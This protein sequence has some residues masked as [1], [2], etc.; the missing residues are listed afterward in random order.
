MQ[1]GQQEVEEIWQ[2]SK[3]FP[4]YFGSNK[5]RVK[6]NKGHIMSP[7]T[8]KKG[9]KRLALTR[10]K[11]KFKIAVSRFISL[12]FTPNIDNLPEVDHRNKIRSDNNISNLKWS[13]RK[14]NC[15]NRN[16]PTFDPDYYKM[17]II[18]DEEWKLIPGDWVFPYKISNYGRIWV[19]KGKS[20]GSNEEYKRVTLTRPDKTTETRAI[21]ILVA[22]C[23]LI[24]PTSDEILIVDHKDENKHN[25]KASNLQ[26]ITQSKNTEKS[27]DAGTKKRK[28]VIQ[29]TLEGDFVAKF[30]SAKDAAKSLGIGREHISGT[31]AGNRKSSGGF[32]WVFE[33]DWDPNAAQK[34]VPRVGPRPVVQIDPKTDKI[35]RAFKSTTEAQRETGICRKT[36]ADAAKG[37]QKLAGGFRWAFQEGPKLR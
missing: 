22:Q 30:K 9:Y 16:P 33:K 7:W 24:K 21:H 36:I 34:P 17:N 10:N 4:G 2:E 6:N 31:A 1:E 8:T 29:L 5:G 19:S 12:I 26:W 15:N 13:T 27:Y 32:R 37:K 3:E 23:F 28:A 18:E 25:N 14:D 11:K 35:I 20:Y